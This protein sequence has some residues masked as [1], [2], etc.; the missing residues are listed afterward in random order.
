MSPRSTCRTACRPGRRS[1]NGSSTA[2]TAALADGGQSGVK[3]VQGILEGLDDVRFSIL[4]SH[5]VVRHRLVSAIV[6]AYGRF[7]AQQPALAA[8]REAG[9]PRGGRG[10][11]R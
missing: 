11:R 10:N 7:D 5:D 4:T 6:D 2:P 8:G 9:R 3:I 1:S